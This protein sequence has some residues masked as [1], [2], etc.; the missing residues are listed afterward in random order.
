[1]QRI[2]F[3]TL[4]CPDWSWGDVL[5][6]G[7]SWGYE[8]VEIR[9]LQRD[10]E[11]LARPEFQPSQIAAR[12]RELA[13]AG[14]NVCGLASSVRFDSADAAERRRQIDTGRRY[15]ELAAA[16]GAEFVRVFGDVLPEHAS[17][18]VRQAAMRQVA[19]GLDQLGSF[20]HSLG[21]QVLIETHG[22]F[23]DSRVVAETLRQVES[24]A[25]GVLWDTHHPWRFVGEELAATL[26]RLQPWVRHTHWKD[27]V[28]RAMRRG[29]N[30]ARQAEMA[31]AAAAAHRLMTGHRHADYV[32]FGG[33]EFPAVDCLRLLRE[34]GYRGWYCL[35]WEQMWHPELEPPEVALPL[36]P[37]KLRELSGVS[38]L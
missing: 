1:M 10:T 19:E 22:D 35:E 23:A 11:L 30:E 36:F 9:L 18:E 6:F 37:R 25:V 2:A 5:R 4:G 13:Q 16:L 14:L 8:G 21:V 7:P 38:G 28:S 15:C 26:E 32:L 29:V 20:A 34:G 17:P 33:G 12:R 24:G 31:E 3:S 27:S